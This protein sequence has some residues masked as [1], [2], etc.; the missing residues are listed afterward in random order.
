[1]NRTSL[2]AIVN[3]FYRTRVWIDRRRT[4][5]LL[6]SLDARALRDFGLSRLDAW[7][8]ARTPFWRD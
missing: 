3:L 4:R 2:R 8:E 5:D 1:M 7:P 6:R